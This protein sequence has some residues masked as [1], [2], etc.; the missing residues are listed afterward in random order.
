MKLLCFVSCFQTPVTVSVR[1]PL[2]QN[3]YDFTVTISI[4]APLCSSPNF[5]HPKAKRLE[6]S[7]RPEW[8]D[9][10]T[11]TWSKGSEGKGVEANRHLSPQESRQ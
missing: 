1:Q 5:K 8:A 9:I 10:L 11:S 7:G 4:L 6:W 2:I 3:P